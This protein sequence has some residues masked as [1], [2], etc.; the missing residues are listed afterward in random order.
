M[1]YLSRFTR[2]VAIPQHALGF[3]GV[4]YFYYHP[5]SWHYFFLVYLC[6]CLIGVFGVSTVYHKIYAHRSF[7]VKDSLIPF[8]YFFTLLGMLS[9][10]GSPLSYAAVHRSYHHPNADLNGFDPHSPNV[11][12]FWHAYY[13]WHFKMFNYNFRGIKDLIANRF[14][15]FC[16]KYYYQFFVVFHLLAALV[17]FKY[18]VLCVVWPALFHV[19][20]MNIL[21]SFSHKKWFGYRNF[22]SYDKSVNNLV[23]G[24]LTWG[25]GFHNNHHALPSAYH[26]QIKWYEFD[27]FRWIVPL[28]KK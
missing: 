1:L 25:T 15:S 16:H 18:L 8:L 4:V 27:P 19:H 22:E 20:Q 6:W 24:I 9:G 23:F 3:A 10:Q 12:S 17:S 28:I 7:E 11:N 26:N 14:L 5:I 21:N 2:Y 13:G